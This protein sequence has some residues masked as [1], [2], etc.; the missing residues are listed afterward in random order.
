MKK[1]NVVQMF[2]NFDNNNNQ[3]KYFDEFI[4]KCKLRD[5]VKKYLINKN[6]MKKIKKIKNKRN[7][8]IHNFN[9][10]FDINLNN[11]NNNNDNDKK[12]I[13]NYS[14]K[15]KTHPNFPI[16]FNNNNNNK[17]NKNNNIKEKNKT[18]YLMKLN[19]NLDS[20]RENYKKFMNY[21]S[22]I[23]NT[24]NNNNNQPLFYEEKIKINILNNF[25]IKYNNNIDKFKMKKYFKNFG[26]IT[27]I[28]FLN[29]N[30]N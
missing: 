2:Y 16:I 5:E 24:E 12:I 27:Q 1:F 4:P 25:Q 23:Y 19:P 20:I 6:K 3:I 14:T 18:N 30:N 13:R 28:K 29:N 15:I 22:K 26:E 9:K 7:L 10:V 8:S 17:N 11:S 21:K